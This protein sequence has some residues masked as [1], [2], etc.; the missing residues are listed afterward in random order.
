MEQSEIRVRTERGSRYRKLNGEDNSPAPRLL[1]WNMGDDHELPPPR[2]W[3]LEN[4]FCKP[5]LSG[6]AGSGGLGKTALRIVQM[7]AL[8]TGRE[9]LDERVLGRGR[10]RVLLISFED[11]LLEIRRRIHAATHHYGIPHDELLDCFW[12]VTPLEL[13]IAEMSDENRRICAGTGA[14]EL[15]R[16]I[17]EKRI[18][19]VC[20]DP[21]IK[22][23]EAEENSNNQIDQVC[24]LLVRIATE[25]DCA[26]DLIHHVG[27]GLVEPGDSNRMRGASALR[28]AM[29]LLYTVTPMS[30]KEAKDF[31]VSAVERKSLFRLDPAKLNILPPASETKWFRLV[32]IRL[33]NGDEDYPNGDRMQTVERWYPPPP[34]SKIDPAVQQRILDRL[35][36]GPEPGRRYSL[37]LQ[38]KDE[39]LAWRVVQTYCPELTRLQCQDL[40]KYWIKAK[41]LAERHYLDPTERKDRYGLYVVARPLG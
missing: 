27:K 4:T 37:R 38:S 36:I 13:K 18:D 10:Y 23:H 30:D 41:V 8:A 21:F 25:C 3:L 6:L 40:L 19:L 28:D 24:I 39:R 1:L 15:R 34:I 12:V 7:L 26:V 14:A 32:E 33:K 17:T 16:V 29:R 35:E 11:D 2:G 20:I 5:F 31:E 9:L 22:S